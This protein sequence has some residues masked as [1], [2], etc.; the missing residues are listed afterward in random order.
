MIIETSGTDDFGFLVF[1]TSSLPKPQ[2]PRLERG[3]S[4]TLIGNAA[5]FQL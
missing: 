2:L 3:S 4:V 5:T 1:G